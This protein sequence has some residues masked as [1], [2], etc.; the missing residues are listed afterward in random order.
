VFAV[1]FTN[2][3]DLAGADFQLISC[4]PPWAYK[5]TASA[6]ER[7][8][9]FKYPVLSLED[10]AALPVRQ[11]AAKDCVLACWT[12]GPF[13]VDGSCERVIRAW[14]F[15]P[16]TMAFTW[17]KKTKHGKCSLSA[18]GGGREQSRVLRPRD[19]R[20]AE[21]SIG[22]RAFRHRSADRSIL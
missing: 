20:K 18:W 17:V 14:G 3:S 5:D 11:I 12:T 6:G 9:V 19:T 13:L 15:T 1:Y 7:G 16:K 4:D 2:L 10:I 8:A 22:W 21:T